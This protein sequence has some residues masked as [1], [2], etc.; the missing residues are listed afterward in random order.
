VEALGPQPCDA[1]HVVVRGRY[2][3]A[4]EKVTMTDQTQNPFDLGS[5]RRAD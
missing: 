2:V 4:K 1:I 5:R 3:A